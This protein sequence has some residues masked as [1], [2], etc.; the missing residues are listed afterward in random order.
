VGIYEALHFLNV[1]LLRDII[2]IMMCGFNSFNMPFNSIYL[3]QAKCISPNLGRVSPDRHSFI[4]KQ[5][6]IPLKRP[7][8][9]LTFECTEN[10]L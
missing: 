1:S 9:R 3:H 8:F 10:R 7:S 2:I 5:N 4:D 6:R